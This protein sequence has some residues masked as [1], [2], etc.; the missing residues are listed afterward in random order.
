MS[1]AERIPGM[2]KPSSR[3]IMPGGTLRSSARADGLVTQARAREVLRCSGARFRRRIRE[4]RSSSAGS[5][6][7]LLLKH[8]Q[9]RVVGVA[10]ID[11]MTS[12][13]WPG[14]ALTGRLPPVGGDEPLVVDLGD[15]QP[16]AEPHG[17]QFLLP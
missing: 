14:I 8:S 16:A 7:A 15:E 17:W 6:R 1:I 12:S 3:P 10:V 4:R 11:T 9:G 13:Q 2:S 5:R